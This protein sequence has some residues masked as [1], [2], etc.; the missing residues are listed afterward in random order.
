MAGRSGCASKAG[1]Q[2]EGR[3]AGLRA[4]LRKRI[5]TKPM[6][7]RAGATCQHTSPA[8]AAPATPLAQRS[9]AHLNSTELVGSAFR[10]CVYS[11]AAFRN[12]PSLYSALPCSLKPSD[13]AAAPSAALLAAAGSLPLPPLPMLL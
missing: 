9:R 10:P 7:A 4:D 3:D 1:W 8:A 6:M 5:G 13:A 2:R 12:L 11:A